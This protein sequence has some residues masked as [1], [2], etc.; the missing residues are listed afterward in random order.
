MPDNYVLENLKSAVD[1]AFDLKTEAYTKYCRIRNLTNAAYE[2]MQADWDALTEA[3][4][5][6]KHEYDVIY[7]GPSKEI[8]EEYAKYRGKL[9]GEIEDLKREMATERH[10]MKRCF[11]KARS[12]SEYGN[13]DESTAFKEEGYEHKEL[14]HEID[15]SIREKRRKIREAR[16]KAEEKAPRKNTSEYEAARLAFEEAKAK[17]EASRAKFIH[18]K[19]ERNFLREKL[20]SAESLYNQE[21]ARYLRKAE[22]NNLG[23]ETLNDP[24][25]KEFKCK[26]QDTTPKKGL[27]SKITSFLFG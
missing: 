2:E 7:D 10:E 6:L 19:G 3:R 20:D 9:H 17:H 4:D 24:P 16:V 11:N 14:L 12:S 23:E 27:L 26:P 25:K 21:K 8:W 22:T 15:K 13:E 1:R 5:N 18:L